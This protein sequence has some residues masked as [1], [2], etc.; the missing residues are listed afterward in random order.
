METKNEPVI[1]RLTPVGARVLV[2]IYKKPNITSSGFVLPESETPGMPTLAMI[3]VLGKKTLW[4]RL[5]MLIGLKAR[6][7]VGQWVYFRKYSVDELR[8]NNG[9]N[10][11][12]LY[13]LEEAEIIGLVN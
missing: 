3:S 1:D 11:L 6:Y 13:V 4:Q 10:E 12:L 7:K 5:Q 9:D 2:N 8:I